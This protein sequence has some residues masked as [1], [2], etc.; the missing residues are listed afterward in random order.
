VSHGPFGI[1]VLAGGRGTRLGGRDKPG[2]VVAGRTLIDAVVAA[3][4]GAGAGQIVVVG[5]GRAGLD[6]VSF[7]REDPP[8]A[9]PVPA[10]RRGL[11]EAWPPWVAVLAADLPFLRPGH[12][13][14]LRQ[15]AAGHHGAVYADDAGRSQ[16]LVGC[17]RTEILR[18]AA[19]GY[20]GTSLGG[21]LGPLEPVLVRL[22]PAPG[23]PPPWLDCDT[24]EDLD[25]ARGWAP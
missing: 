7:V 3:G 25:R 6:G 24:P 1:I 16:W 17:W 10:L 9:G 2:L 5:P 14:A 21:L 11:A 20:Q 13:Q 15:A 4:T 23:E 8:G 19:A 22:T 18:H 12:L